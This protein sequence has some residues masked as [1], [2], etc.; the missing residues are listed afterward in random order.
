MNKFY[1]T[2]LT[3]SYHQQIQ[4]FT[5]R[6]TERY[7]DLEEDLKEPVMAN[8]EHFVDTSI[9][10]FLEKDVIL[11][12]PEIC[13]MELPTNSSQT[14]VHQTFT[15]PEHDIWVDHDSFDDDLFPTFTFKHNGDIL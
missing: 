7:K 15:E 13:I 3:N 6:K 4:S 14:P 12:T 8:K 11:L 1:P 10:N 9:K 2:Q 5:Q